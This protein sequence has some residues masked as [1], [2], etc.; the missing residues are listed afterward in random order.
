QC[1]CR[2]DH[3]HQRH[4]RSPDS[5]SWQELGIALRPDR[6]ISRDL[7]GIERSPGRSGQSTAWLYLCVFLRGVCCAPERAWVGAIGIDFQHRVV[8]L[9][10]HSALGTSGIMWAMR[11]WESPGASTSTCSEHA[12]HPVDEHADA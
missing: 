8:E 6:E 9:T 2:V 1:T 5:A 3:I 12:D 4:L 11:L 7:Y 10:G